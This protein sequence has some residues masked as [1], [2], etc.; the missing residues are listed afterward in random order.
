[1]I[2][3]YLNIDQKFKDQNTDKLCVS[4][5]NV[6]LIAKKEPEISRV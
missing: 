1:L 5:I 4:K 6:C 2:Q 3:I